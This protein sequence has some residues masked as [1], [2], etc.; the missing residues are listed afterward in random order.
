MSDPHED[1]T[2]P[3][4]SEVTALQE[5]SDS[6]HSI[7][8]YDESENAT[9]PGT[10]PTPDSMPQASTG[11]TAPPVQDQNEDEDENMPETDR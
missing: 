2:E 7:V 9:N 11:K 10:D 6:E 3:I 8:G 5:S 1:A 4:A